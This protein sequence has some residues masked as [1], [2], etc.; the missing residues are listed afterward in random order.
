M[1]IELVNNFGLCEELP[2]KNIVHNIS[3]YMSYMKL[4]MKYEIIKEILI[5][6]EIIS[7]DNK[8]NI[9]IIPCLF[10]I[11]NICTIEINYD[12][13]KIRYT[14]KYDK[15]IAIDSKTIESLGDFHRKTVEWLGQGRFNI[16][17]L[18]QGIEDG[19]INLLHILD[20]LTGFDNESF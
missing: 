16:D 19:R 5:N 14:L 8:D 11:E 18:I 12:N 3:I 17:E 4:T 10:T 7:Y 6:G 2:L 15:S 9:I 13:E 1:K 20:P